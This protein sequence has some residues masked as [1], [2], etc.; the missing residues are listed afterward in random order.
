MRIS[1]I[2]ISKESIF[3]VTEI[4][5][6]YCVISTSLSINIARVSANGVD[7]WPVPSVNQSVGLSACPESVL[8]QNVT[9]SGCR[10][11]L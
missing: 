5:F 7:L 1:D 8:W 2:C 4:L 6:S 10:L 11:G 9:G 3:A